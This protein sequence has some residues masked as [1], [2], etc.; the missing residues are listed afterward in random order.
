VGTEDAGV[1]LIFIFY[2]CL[3]IYGVF[4]FILGF[5]LNLFTSKSTIFSMFYFL[6]YIKISF[7]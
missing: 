4:F 1:I 3:S 6:N 5:F 7:Q 2:F